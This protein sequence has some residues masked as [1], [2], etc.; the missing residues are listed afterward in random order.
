[1][2]IYK[3]PFFVFFIYVFALIE[4]YIPHVQENIVI[5][6]IGHHIIV[7]LVANYFFFTHPEKVI[8]IYQYKTDDI[9]EFYLYIPIIT[10]SYGFYELMSASFLKKKFEFMFHG[11]LMVTMSV[12]VLEYEIFHWVYPGL[13]METSSIFLNLLHLKNKI[14][15]YLFALTFILYRNILFPYICLCFYYK[16]FGKFI[17]LN[18]DHNLEKGVGLLISVVNILNFFWGYKIIKKVFNHY[19]LQ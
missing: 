18:P 15:K 10:C 6:N 3:L 2:V 12:F 13:L 4:R 5:V 7:S 17:S 14:Y 11:M 16:N 19:K 9:S 1:M 8:N